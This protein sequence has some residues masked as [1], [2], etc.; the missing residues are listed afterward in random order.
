MP[1]C[2]TL[3]S[4]A[5]FHV[6]FAHELKVECAELLDAVFTTEIHKFFPSA[7]DC[8]SFSAIEV[9]VP[10]LWLSAV[11][12]LAFKVVSAEPPLARS[13]FEA[14]EKMPVLESLNVD[15]HSATYRSGRSEGAF[16]TF[17]PSLARFKGRWT[18]VQHLV[19]REHRCEE[20]VVNLAGKTVLYPLNAR[21]VVI[22]FANIESFEDYDGP[23][24][25]ESTEILQFPFEVQPYEWEM[26]RRW[27]ELCLPRVLN[28]ITR[29]IGER[30]T[31][32]LLLKTQFEAGQFV[33]LAEMIEEI[34][35]CERRIDALLSECEKRGI[36][37]LGL[38]LKLNVRLYEA[39]TY[40]E[41]FMKKFLQT[42]KQK[43]G[44]HIPQTEREKSEWFRV[45]SEKRTEFLMRISWDH[46]CDSANNDLYENEFD[47]L[48]FDCGLNREEF[49]ERKRGHDSD[50]SSEEEDE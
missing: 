40:D 19:G 16:P 37:L 15:M 21:K 42:L 39:A 10:L 43:F 28:G 7:V 4:R 9:V 5:Y 46:Y 14:I 32:F 44:P 12:R 27:K 50:D 31:P 26:C 36:R 33:K 8:V 34:E 24:P 1:C 20:V 13:M 6:F 18:D 17:P 35:T 29:V 2:L 23:L 48:E 3:V 25:L 47:E 45:E 11:R 41:Q 22:E 38:R 49:D 30:K